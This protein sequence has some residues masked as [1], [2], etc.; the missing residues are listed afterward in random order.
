MCS[1][2]ALWNRLKSQQNLCS[3]VPYVL[4]TVRITRISKKKY[5]NSCYPRAS[6]YIVWK[7]FPRRISLLNEN[8]TTYKKL[9]N[10]FQNLSRTHT[11][12]HSP[13]IDL[14]I[15]SGRRNE[16]IENG[17]CDV[18]IKTLLRSRQTK[19]IKI[20]HKFLKSWISWT[21]VKLL[22]IS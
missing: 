10:F 12:V 21:T 22:T 14:Y 13:V 6:T 18:K 20:W 1:R 15:A 5:L 16:F 11:A 3:S 7:I 4:L 9:F 19:I 17:F 8:T 2:D